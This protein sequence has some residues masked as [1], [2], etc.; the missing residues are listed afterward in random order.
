MPAHKKPPIPA[1]GR[2]RRVGFLWVA[3]FAAAAVTLALSVSPG[4]DRPA[5]LTPVE[6]GLIVVLVWL[7]VWL[8][9]RTTRQI[10]LE[11]LWRSYSIAAL[12][13]AVVVVGLWQYG[14]QF[15]ADTLMPG[16]GW[17]LWL[18]L[19]TLPHLMFVLSQ[20]VESTS[21]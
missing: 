6:I 14:G 21:K 2:L 3:A 11:G 20:P 4:A 9:A 18:L 12:L 13:P 16:V 19:Y 5:W 15:V 8:Q 10:S 1:P 7:T 17:R